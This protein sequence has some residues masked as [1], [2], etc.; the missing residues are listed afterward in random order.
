MYVEILTDFRIHG[1]HGSHTFA[2]L[3]FSV[4]MD[5]TVIL[6][7]FSRNSGD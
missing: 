3:N 5:G 1:Y 4:F 6:I 2:K 7:F